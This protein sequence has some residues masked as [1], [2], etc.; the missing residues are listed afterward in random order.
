MEPVYC[1][2]S[3]ILPPRENRKGRTVTQEVRTGHVCLRPPK[4]RN[5]KLQPIEV[6]FV[7]CTEKNAPLGETPLEWLLLT[8]VPIKS[9][10]DALTI[11]MW[12]LCRWQIEIF[13]KF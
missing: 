11:V 10:E 5:E 6:T 3:F 4:G 12:Y 8:S 13:L 7:L 1:E 2:Y 9:D